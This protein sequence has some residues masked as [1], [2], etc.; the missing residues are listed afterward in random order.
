MHKENRVTVSQE[1]FDRS[2]ATL[3]SR[4]GPC[5][6]FL[7]PE[8]EILTKRSPISDGRGDKKIRHGTFAPSLKTRSR[9]A[10]NV[11]SGVSRVE[12]STMKETI[13]IKLYVKQ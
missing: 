3:L 12:G 6:L 11:G 13:L 8:V 4:F 2:N 9:T 1:L 5:G 7:G 10:K